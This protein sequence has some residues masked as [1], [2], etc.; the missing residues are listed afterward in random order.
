MKCAFRSRPAP[1]IDSVRRLVAK[2]PT[3]TTNSYEIGP[4]PFNEMQSRL[5]NNEVRVVIVSDVNSSEWLFY[6]TSLYIFQEK[7]NLEFVKGIAM[8]K[9]EKKI[10]I[11]E[12]NKKFEQLAKWKWKRWMDGMVLCVIVND[13]SNISVAP[14]L[15]TWEVHNPQGH[16]VCRHTCLQRKTSSS[17]L[18]M[19]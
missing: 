14:R 19:K 13:L 2:R 4:H 15:A 8:K 12:V 10:I 5:N 9:E 1:L 6:L 3:S 17:Y 18:Y 16:K 11:K 7:N